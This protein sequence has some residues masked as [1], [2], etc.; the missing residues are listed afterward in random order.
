MG[1]GRVSAASRAGDSLLKTFGH[2]TLA[3]A[4][5]AAI[6]AGVYII[7]TDGHCRFINEAGLRL[8][9]YSAEEVLGRNMHALIHHSHTD[10]SPYPEHACP[11]LR[12]ITAG[13]AVR[14]DNEILWRKDGSFFMAEYSSAPIQDGGE[15]L[16][17]IVIFRDR[18]DHAEAQ[19]RLS[20]QFAV[21]RILA[22]EAN[23]ETTPLRIL[24]AIGGAF[25]W[26]S[27]AFWVRAEDEEDLQRQACWCNAEGGDADAEDRYP[28]R[29]QARG[30]IEVTP[31]TGGASGSAPAGW[32]RIDIPVMLG[33]D[34]LGLIAFGSAQPIRLDED[35]RN[36]LTSLGQQIGHFLERARIA[37]RLREREKQYRF[38]ADSIPQLVWTALRDGKL[39][40]VNARWTEYCGLP[41]ER[42][43]GA[44][45]E[46]VVHPDDIAA[47][48]RAWEVSIA[49][50]CSYVVESRLRGAE[51]G[52]RWFLSR[53]VP[54]KSSTGRVLR[55]FG[56]STD[57]EDAKR[58]ED[59]I[60]RS[61]QRFR[62]LIEAASAIVWLATPTGHLETEQPS[63][64][65]FTGQ[66][67]Q[68]YRGGGWL[69]AVH[70]AD[71]ALT[72]EVWAEA[73]QNRTMYVVE[74]RLRRHDGMYRHMA[75]RAVPI[76]DREGQIREWIGLHADTTEQRQTDHALRESRERLRAALLASRTGTFRWDI[77]TDAFEM[78]E[79]FERLVGLPHADS[80]RTIKEAVAAFIHPED[81]E[82][83]Q[84]EIA[85]IVSGGTEVDIE[86]R[87]LRNDTGEVRWIS[88]KGATTRDLD[89]RPLHM[90][91][92]CVDITDRRRFED[93]LVSAKEAAEEANRA[94]SQFIANMSH[95]LRTPLSAVI[96]YTELIEEELT[97]SEAET[98]SEILEDI[99][100]IRGNARHLLE[101]INDVLDLSKIEAGKM[102]VQ[103][104]DFEV[105]PAL[106]DISGTVQALVTKNG[107]ALILD[108]PDDL[109]QM[110]SDATKL[111]QSLLNLLS[112]AAKFTE[113]GTVTLS[114]RRVQE[115]K[116]G[117]MLRFT[118][119]DTGIGIDSE[120]QKKLFQRFSQIDA[121]TTRKFGGTGL[122]LALTRAFCHMLGGDISV[123]S[124]KGVGTRFTIELPADMRAVRAGVEPAG[125][126]DEPE[127]G[128]DLVL[129]I[130]DDAPTRDL[131]S[132]FLAREGFAVRSATDGEAGLELARSL[133]PSAILLDVMMPHMDGWAV[134]SAL[135]ADPDLA[136]IP[137]IMISVVQEKSLAFSLGAADYLTKPVDWR[138]FKNTME[139]YRT[140]D[141]LGSAL[142][143]IGDV[144]TRVE[145]RQLLEAEGWAVREAG[146]AD[147]ALE[148]IAKERPQAVLL[149]LQAPEL[150]GLSFLR[151]LRK[152][153]DGKSLPV[154]AV[155]ERGLTPQERARL[156]DQ[157]RQIVQADDGLAED[158]MSELRSIAKKAAM[159][160]GV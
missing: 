2:G 82:R 150:D 91:G 105:L 107:N 124:E 79:G 75:V 100:K 113:N 110:H 47:M 11:L 18:S 46:E 60:R 43:I 62:S 41:F 71:R 9:G 53:G 157:V 40:Y 111:R 70:P 142:L 65:A 63:W 126:V 115:A 119:Q 88:G 133:R 19:T 152:L 81:Q 28:S 35:L 147:A 156:Q 5:L 22:G 128:E 26:Q 143:I 73:V 155:T 58:A 29:T 17:G 6:E 106:Q 16:G 30:G 57:V 141:L 1:E 135:K 94:K 96:G 66:R 102:D 140:P 97:E 61:E 98:T 148:E 42:A 3:E 83:I 20:V 137:V 149:D 121:S 93:E 74:H 109:G 54:L 145:L 101:L 15:I 7:G 55:W 131:L 24:Q 77:R 38:M 154:I 84:A 122:G 87:V 27:G 45:W 112:N 8:I 12:T 10:G 123:Q 85:R 127:A 139:R 51:G 117:A 52:Y 31:G 146:T 103:P 118:V 80:P 92:A 104:E 134:L 14:L 151:A 34:I 160:G 78:D 132:R 49:T 136:E 114:A 72:E 21:S 68:D 56:T 159:E 116:G 144:Q 67:F 13:Q 59:E 44:G 129:V 69:D 138:R 50:G 90:I 23:L 37:Q 89:N 125:E 36:T 130:D 76:L 108:L 4:A 95:E 48:R 86:F 39:D 32:H 158:L 25:G 33:Q 120:Q 99:Q 153:P 64:A